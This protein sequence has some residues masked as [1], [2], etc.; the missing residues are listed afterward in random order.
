MAKIRQYKEGGPPPPPHRLASVFD[1]PAR[2][3]VLLLTCMDQRL[4]DD[5][6]RFMNALN[7]HN[8]YDQVAL[9]GGTMGVQ[10]LNP[11]SSV[12]QP[13]FFDHLHAAIDVL[14]RQIKDVFLFEHLDCGA[15]RYLHPDTTIRDR[16]SNA[17][18]LVMTEIHRNEARKFAWEV[19]D[20]INTQRRLHETDFRAARESCG[21]DSDCWDR[22]KESAKQ[23]V[24]AW[25]NIRVSYFVMDLLGEV[26]QLDLP[27]GQRAAFER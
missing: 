1:D 14:H 15:Y 17:D 20:F 25:T 23:K 19:A 12:W 2:N 22:V 27:A 9:A 21:A 16:Y 8:R 4:L 26:T 3:K 7:L 5:T 6:V 24:D 18:R 13:V 11:P 10:R